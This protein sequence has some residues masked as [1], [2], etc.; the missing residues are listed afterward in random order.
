MRW[1]EPIYTGEK[2]RKRLQE[3]R[4]LLGALSETGYQELGFYVLVSPANGKNLMELLPAYY[5]KQA[6]YREESLAVLGLAENRREAFELCRRILRDCY[7][8]HGCIRRELL[9]NSVVEK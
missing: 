4:R 8:C 3:Y 6:A 7:I 1:C 2:A 9:F 5:L